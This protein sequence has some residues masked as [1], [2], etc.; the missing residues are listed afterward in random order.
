[1]EKV[2]ERAQFC[3]GILV[4]NVV[5]MLDPEYVIIGGGIAERLGR[6]YVTPI[7]KTAYQYFLRR[8]DARRVKIVPGVLGDDAGPLGAVVLARQR[9]GD[10]PVNGLPHNCIRGVPLNPPHKEETTP[11]G[12][13]HA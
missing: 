11:E 7:R 3:L 2:M 12:R 13:S 8:H 4:A 1:M 9:L 5:N 6:D 10:K